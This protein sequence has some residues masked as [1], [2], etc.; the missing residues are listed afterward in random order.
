MSTSVKEVELD[1]IPAILFIPEHTLEFDIDLKVWQD[2]VAMKY[3]R[4]Y[5]IEEVKEMIA[6]AEE[7]YIDPEARYVITDEGRAYLDRLEAGG[8]I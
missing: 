3:S 4:H 6:N 2:G 5:T 7:N 8:D 1:T